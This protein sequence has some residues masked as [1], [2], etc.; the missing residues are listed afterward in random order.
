M[1]WS[2]GSLD[3]VP[4]LQRIK[5]IPWGATLSAAHDRT[6]ASLMEAIAQSPRVFLRA[7]D[8]FWMLAEQ[9]RH[10]FIQLLTRPPSGEARP[11]GTQTALNQF[12][13]QWIR[14]MSMHHLPGTPL[15]VH[16]VVPLDRDLIEASAHTLPITLG[17]QHPE[18]YRNLAA[19]TA[20]NGEVRAV[21]ELPGPPALL[22]L[23]SVPGGLRLATCSGEPDEVGFRRGAPPRHDEARE[24]FRT[25]FQEAAALQED[26]S[27]AVHRYNCKVPKALQLTL[28]ADLPGGM[29]AATLQR[30]SR[31]SRERMLWFDYRLLASPGRVD[32][33]I[34]DP[35]TQF[36]LKQCRNHAR[37]DVNALNLHPARMPIP[38]EICRQEVVIGCAVQLRVE[39]KQADLPE[40]EKRIR[41]GL[42]IDDIM[43]LLTF[44]ERRMVEAL[45]KQIRPQAPSGAASEAATTARPA[46]PVTYVLQ[47]TGHPMNCMLVVTPLAE[48]ASSK[49]KRAPAATASSETK[50][51]PTSPH[52]VG[53][54]DDAMFDVLVG[55]LAADI[56]QS[57]HWHLLT[58]KL[59]PLLL[60]GCTGW[61]IGRP[62][63]VVQADT[64]AGP[65]WTDGHAGGSATIEPVRILQSP[66]TGRYIGWRDG[67]RVEVS[68]DGDSFYAAVLCS[69]SDAER[70]TLLMACGMDQQ[71]M[72]Y[73]SLAITALRQHVANSL[74]MHRAD[75]RRLIIDLS[76]A[77]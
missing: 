55:T 51:E 57:G 9:T 50:S 65:Q 45:Q 20:T 1:A 21:K 31:A 59:P 58:A 32:E 12:R 52:R 15:M 48:A 29:T 7:D 3:L 37:Q 35:S 36:F 71:Q 61:P 39:A 77:P 10:P 19:T 68:P 63:E 18:G 5:D 46:L 42:S 53:G 6:A 74:F 60:Q 70:Q 66:Q 62:L 40:H 76:A 47:H 8:E 26:L 73:V 2:E 72:A 11:L 16:K 17:A 54:Q 34:T 27:T 30:G 49:Q 69:L 64:L 22:S 56:R 67:Q 43:D 24:H 41:F 13:D 75:Y 33:R 44:P 28:R 4:L 38:A 14:L 23:V 25:V